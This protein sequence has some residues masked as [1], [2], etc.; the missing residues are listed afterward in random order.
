MYQS[1][2]C[3]ANQNCTIIPIPTVSSIRFICSNQIYIGRYTYII[4]AARSS[5]IILSTEKKKNFLSW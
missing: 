2:P 3:K 5:Q 4:D 1:F